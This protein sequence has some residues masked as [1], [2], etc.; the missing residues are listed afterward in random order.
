MGFICLYIPLTMRYIFW[1][2]LCLFLQSQSHDLIEGKVMEWV[3]SDGH[4]IDI[5]IDP[6][7]NILS[8]MTLFAQMRKSK[9]SIY[10][11]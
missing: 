4:I 3:L 8:Y 6:M 9:T 7:T 1:K 5:P 11:V 2:A 10:M